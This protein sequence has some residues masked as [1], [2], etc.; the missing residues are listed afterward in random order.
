MTRSDARTHYDTL[1]L[2]PSATADEIKRAYRRLA[3]RHHPDHNPHDAAAENHF[4]R[5]STAYAALSDPTQ[6]AAYDLSLRAARPAPRSPRP[7]PD[8]PGAASWFDDLFQRRAAARAA[9]SPQTPRPRR[10]RDVAYDIHLELEDVLHGFET[11]LNNLLEHP[12]HAQWHD[13]DGGLRVRIPPG[14]KDGQRFEYKTLGEAGAHGGAHGDLYL[15]ARIAPHPLLVRV[16]DVHLRCE[17]PVSFI[18][19]LLGADVDVPTLE[20]VISL[21]IA[22]NT[23]PGKKLRLRGYGLPDPHT[24]ERGDIVLKVIAET[25]RDLT[26]AQRALLAE[27]ERLTPADDMP[28]RAHFQALLRDR[29]PSDVDP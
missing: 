3:L 12:R 13:D 27:V 23:P 8:A 22:P 16:D 9:Q 14:V 20:G 1:G 2:S 26:D 21:R 28:A 7:S 19:L 15:V 10:G 11:T 6:R 24:R 17:V 4:K 18:Q 25:P 5:I 29:Y